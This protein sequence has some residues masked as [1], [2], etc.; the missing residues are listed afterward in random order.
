MTRGPNIMAAVIL[1]AMLCVIVVMNGCATP[2]PTA[3]QLCR[4]PATEGNAWKWRLACDAVNI[5]KPAPADLCGRY[6]HSELWPGEWRVRC[7]K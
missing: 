3:A 2:G 6:I 1:L 4:A 7:G 5:P